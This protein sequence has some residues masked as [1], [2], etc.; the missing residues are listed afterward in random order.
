MRLRYS[1]FYTV[2]LHPH[3]KRIHTSGVVWVGVEEGG[4]WRAENESYLEICVKSSYSH[5]PRTD[6]NSSLSLK[7]TDS[8]F[9]MKL[10]QTKNTSYIRKGRENSVVLKTRILS[11]CLH[12]DWEP[13]PCR[14]LPISPLLLL[15][16]P[17]LPNW[18]CYP[19]QRTTFLRNLTDSEKTRYWRLEIP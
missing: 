12:Y 17:E 4:N 2:S 15:C 5:L 13:S 10:S 6:S 16:S 19:D 8:F 9:Q 7:E 14:L 1:A 3:S 18:A 11:K